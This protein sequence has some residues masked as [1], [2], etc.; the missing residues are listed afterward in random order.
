[1]AV[2]IEW[3]W[4]QNA[5]V[6]PGR[7]LRTRVQALRV[8]GVNGFRGHTYRAGKRC[9]VGGGES[10][11]EL[12]ARADPWPSPTARVGA[13]AGVRAVEKLYGTWRLESRTIPCR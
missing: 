10:Y 5:G 2:V 11:P 1:M 3:D 9:P 12:C 8:R 13:P 7:A 6:G 4:V